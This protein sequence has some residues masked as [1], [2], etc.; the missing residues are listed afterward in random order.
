MGGYEVVATHGL[1]PRL[2]EGE[3]VLGITV[4]ENAGGTTLTMVVEVMDG[5]AHRF[6]ATRPAPGEGLY[7]GDIVVMA[8]ALSL[9]SE[10]Y[11]KP[12]VPGID[13]EGLA[14]AVYDGFVSNEQWWS[15]VDM[16]G[17]IGELV[18]SLSMGSRSR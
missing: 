4:E 18:V 6:W 9:P 5:F 15:S 1:M 14:R 10:W 12:F 2:G 17:C 16:K 8:N 11:V 13:F 7:S 3:S